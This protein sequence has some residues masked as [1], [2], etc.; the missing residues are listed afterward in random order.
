[1]SKPDEVE[2]RRV[3]SGC[4]ELWAVAGVHGDEVE[5]I[6][7]VEDALE[8]VR[9]LRGTLVAVPVAHPAALAAGTRLGPDGLDLN[10]TYPGC[11]DGRPTE[12]VANALW[13]QLAPSASALVTLHS[14]SR[15]GCSAPYVE[16]GRGDSRGRDLAHRLGLPFAEPWDWPDGLLPKV[17]VAAGIPAVELELGG[18]GRHTANNL[19]LG[20]QA[21]RAAAAW[22][23]MLAP[24]H[25]GST[26]TVQRHRLL[27]EAAGRVRQL[28]RL[29]DPVAAGEPVCELRSRDGTVV[30]TLSSPVAG[31]VGVHVSYG[32]VRAGTE[33]AIVFEETGPD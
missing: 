4:P 16:Y 3:G 25:T 33:A 1:V 2:I 32:E 24:E 10:R 19:A 22:L 12:R 15:S 9:P 7:C 23:V 27:A 17:A 8:S 31:W 6:A 11:A 20:L 18:L 13:R 28:R 29:G 26:R 30:E 5:G 21:I 14:W